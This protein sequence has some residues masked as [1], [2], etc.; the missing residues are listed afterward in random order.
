MGPRLDEKP[1]AKTV[2]CAKSTVQYWFNQ[3]KES[4]DLSDMKCSKSSR[5]ITEKVDQRISKLEDSDRI[6]TK[7]D[8]EEVLK[9][10]NIKRLFDED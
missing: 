1:V 5:E 10:Q 9:Q 4:K 8:R 6:G 3:W 2:R 7:N